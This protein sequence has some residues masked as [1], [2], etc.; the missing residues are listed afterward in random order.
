ML[1]IVIFT[2]GQA[3]T[4]TSLPGYLN[5]IMQ[6]VAKGDMAYIGRIGATMLVMT[7]TMGI[8]MVIVGYFSSYVTAKFTTR[9]R[10]DIF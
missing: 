3:Y 6:G 10:A 9:I 8:C 7:V 5:E 2:V 1:F 4:Q